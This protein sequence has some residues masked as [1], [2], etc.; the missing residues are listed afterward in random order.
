LSELQQQLDE[1]RA[2]TLT[3]LDAASSDLQQLK[4]QV[5]VVWCGVV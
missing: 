3:K 4:D 1:A 2:A 5:R